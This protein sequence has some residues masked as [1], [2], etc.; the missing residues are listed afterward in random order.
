VF[1]IATLASIGLPLL[2]NFVGEFLILQGAAQ[3][4]IWWAA[5]A[6]LGVVLSAC[7]MLWFYPANVFGRVARRNGGPP[8]LRVAGGDPAAAPHALDGH[9]HAD[10]AA[11]HQRLE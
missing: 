9:L 5:F 3:A 4:N 2:N 7:Y 6:A 1:L 8:P 10:L 11:R